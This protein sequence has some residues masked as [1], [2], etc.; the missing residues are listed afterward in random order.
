MREALEPIAVARAA[1]GATAEQL[2][3][4]RAAL[5]RSESFAERGQT[6]AYLEANRQF[7]L[8]SFQFDG[9]PR[10]RRAIEG[11]WNTTSRH[12]A[13]FRLVADRQEMGGLEHRLM[14]DAFERHAGDDAAQL[15]LLHVRRS[16][17]FFSAAA[18]IT[19]AGAD[20]DD[21]PDPHDA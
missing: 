7:H 2:A 5:E 17:E 11:L 9:M 12:R 18:S 16:R 15:H 3:R 8:L 6:D 20:D 21:A 4:M 10:L 14:L 1:A 19:T 13:P